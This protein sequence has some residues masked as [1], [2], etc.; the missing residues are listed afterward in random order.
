MNHGD[1]RE[2]RAGG[3]V[4][5]RGP[6]TIGVPSMR[7]GRRLPATAAR[8]RSAERP[9]GGAFVNAAERRAEHLFPGTTVGPVDPAEDALVGEAQAPHGVR[10]RGEFHAPGRH[11]EDV[12]SAGR[13]EHVRPL[14]ETRE[15][16]A[17]L[18]VADEAEAA[19]RRDV[20][21]NAAHAAA[22]APKREVQR[23][24]CHVNASDHESAP[25]SSLSLKSLY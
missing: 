11:L 20:A 12:R 7:G 25:T 3:G 18:T 21:R 2:A 9:D 22:P 16:L 23:Q 8:A 5:N 14:Q 10:T 6:V 17:V 15:R 13:V 19:G 1:D 24:A 4:A